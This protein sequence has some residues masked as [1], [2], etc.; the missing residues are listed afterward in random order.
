M[1]VLFLFIGC[2]TFL[3]YNQD[4]SKIIEKE[5]LTDNVDIIFN[6]DIDSCDHCLVDNEIL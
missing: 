4:N 1:G 3:L 2:I 6:D 5:K